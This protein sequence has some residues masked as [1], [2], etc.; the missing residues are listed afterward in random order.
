MNVRNV[1][2]VRKR[3]WLTLN[4]FLAEKGV[5]SG[6]FSHF[7]IILSFSHPPV[8]VADIEKEKTG[9]WR[10]DSLLLASGSFVSPLPYNPW[11]RTNLLIFRRGSWP[12]SSDLW[13]MRQIQPLI[14]ITDSFCYLSP[15]NIACLSRSQMPSRACDDLSYFRSQIGRSYRESYRLLARGLRMTKLKSCMSQI[16]LS[17]ACIN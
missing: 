14:L 6:A 10:A 15:E 4:M 2:N 9:Q 8:S 7:S 1:G 13:V 3:V 12:W 5:Q 17:E 16:C 11:P